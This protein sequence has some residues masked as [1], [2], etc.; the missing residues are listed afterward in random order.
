[1]QREG[2]RVPVP[3]VFPLDARRGGSV[4]VEDAVRSVERARSTRA[5]ADAA[6]HKSTKP[7]AWWP[8]RPIL[9]VFILAVPAALDIARLNCEAAAVQS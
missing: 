3:L 2:V 4:C 5:E 1:V 9:A 6:S 8:M 7:G